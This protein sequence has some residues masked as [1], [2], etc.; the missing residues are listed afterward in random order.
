MRGCAAFP[1]LV[2]Q[3]AQMF[4]TRWEIT[5]SFSNRCILA[6]QRLHQLWVWMLLEQQGSTL[7]SHKISLDFAVAI[8]FCFLNWI[9]QCIGLWYE[10]LFPSCPRIN[11]PVRASPWCLSS[12][13]RLCCLNFFLTAYQ[14]KAVI[15]CF[16]SIILEIDF[17]N[18]L[19]LWCFAMTGCRNQRNNCWALFTYRPVSRMHVIIISQFKVQYQY[20]ITGSLCW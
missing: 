2:S 17:C 12:L 11:V 6:E 10:F 5:M 4:C 3:P 18:T 16:W 1:L 7:A 8:T 14:H 20:W 19:C 9:L 15:P 13:P